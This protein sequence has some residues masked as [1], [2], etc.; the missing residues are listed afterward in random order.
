[1]T[2]VDGTLYAVPTKNKDEF[3]AHA[4]QAAKL[5]KE[6]GALDAVDC[7]GVDIPDGKLTSM[8]MA[9]KCQEGETVCMSWIIWP[10]EEVR[11]QAWEKLME[12]ERMQNM[13]MPFDGKRM[14]FGGF[15]V[16]SQ[17]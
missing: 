10:S 8:P 13:T 11:K 3:R 15:E 5:F 17:A 6:Y 7:W 14:I 12:D 9:V 2:H 4:Q 16:I 1:M